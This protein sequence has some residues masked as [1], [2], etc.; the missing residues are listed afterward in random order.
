MTPGV[1]LPLGNFFRNIGIA[2]MNSL[3]RPCLLAMFSALFLLFAGGAAQAQF[4][5]MA[6][7]SD[8]G[9]TCSVTEHTYE[10]ISTQFQGPLPRDAQSMTLVL[11]DGDL[12]WSNLSPSQIDR[13][14]GGTGDCPLILANEFMPEDGLWRLA[15]GG[16]DSSACPMLGGQGGAAINEDTRQISWNGA[17]HPDKLFAEGTGMIRWSETGRLSWR[18]VMVD[19]SLSSMQGTS[20]ASVIHSVRMVSPTEITGN[21][22]FEYEISAPGMDAAAAAVI[23]G[24]QCRTVTPFTAQKVG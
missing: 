3:I 13:Q 11:D 10:T 12:S 22:V 7:C 4:V 14:Y 18:G 5:Q 21:S 16:T 17:F 20:G 24:M 15:S 1:G 19:E 2:T 23:A 6:T 8:G 9:C